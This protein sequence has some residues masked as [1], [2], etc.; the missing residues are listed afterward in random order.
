MCTAD[1]MVQRTLEEDDNYFIWPHVNYFPVLKGQDED[2][3]W[4]CYEKAT[5]RF[6]IPA[7]SL[8]G[9]AGNISNMIILLKGKLNKSS[10]WLILALAA[11]DTT[12]LLGVNN[13]PL[14]LY[15]RGSRMGFDYPEMQAKMLYYVQFIQ[16]CLETVGKVSSMMLPCLITF[17]RLVAVIAP[18]RYPRIMTVN[19]VRAAIM[20]A[21]LTPIF[22]YIIYCLKFTFKYI[23]E[24]QC[25]ITSQPL[26]E[27]LEGN[28]CTYVGIIAKSTFYKSN[29]QFI[30]LFFRIVVLVYG[31]VNLVL[32]VIGCLIVGIW[33]KYYS[34][35]RETLLGNKN[36]LE[37]KTTFLKKVLGLKTTL[38]CNNKNQSKNIIPFKISISANR[39]KCLTLDP[40][41]VQDGRLTSISTIEANICDL[42]MEVFGT[43][44]D[45]ESSYEIS[46]EKAKDF[47]VKRNHTDE[48]RQ[49]LK[50]RGGRTT[51][52][53]LSVC[54]VYSVASTINFIVL[55]Y[56]NYSGERASS[57]VTIGMEATRRTVIVLNSACNCLF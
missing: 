49:S 9:I 34:I 51:R 42:N 12:F 13:V 19:R 22:P 21:Y 25:N 20:F 16:K 54:A 46:A 18:F 48:R 53:L 31:P 11:A 5:G 28:S 56:F 44:L 4:R 2:D 26:Q 41:A 29:S 40:H 35:S 39:A 32:T 24:N 30:I 45:S 7:I 27:T 14:L 50:K 3:F 52:T 15:A 37:R 8:L 57:D 1:T 55:F 43:S 6:I 17:D 33:L 47:E 10:T 36:T 23:P 38:S